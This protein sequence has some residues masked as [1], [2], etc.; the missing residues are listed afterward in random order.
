MN[1]WT[2]VTAESSAH[3]EKI[4]NNLRYKHDSD[5]ITENNE[6]GIL[7]EN[8]LHIQ[9]LINLADNYEED[10]GFHL[11]PG[12]HKYFTEWANSTVNTYGARFQKLQT[13]IILPD[14]SV[15]QP[16]AQR[17]TMRFDILS[18]VNRFSELEAFSF[19]IKRLL[20]EVHQ[21]THRM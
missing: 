15:I 6:V 9:C 13:F 17:M 10:G 8:T 7:V 16:F 12:F 5:F 21:I 2:Y 14:E 19:G 18:Y 4:L 11:V 20:M 1:P 3:C